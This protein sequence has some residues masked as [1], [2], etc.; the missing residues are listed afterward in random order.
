MNDNSDPLQAI[1]ALAI[2]VVTILLVG[3]TW[4]MGVTTKRTLRVAEREWKPDLQVNLA[5][6]MRPTILEFRNLGRTSLMVVKLRFRDGSGKFR[7]EELSPRLFLVSGDSGIIDMKDY[8]SKWEWLLSLAPKVED[9]QNLEERFPD[10][11]NLKKWLQDDEKVREWVQNQAGLRVW[12]Q[13]VSLSVTFYC[14]GTHSTPEI[15]FDVVLGTPKLGNTRILALK[16]S[17]E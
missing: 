4:W 8:L 5:D 17:T 9:N 16:E 6:P 11:E 14:A 3:V 15:V 13:P 12:S 10:N 1:G 2:V 7:V